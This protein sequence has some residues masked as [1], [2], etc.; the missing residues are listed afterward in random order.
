MAKQT[1]FGN[2][3]WLKMIAGI[4]KLNNAVKVTLGPRGRNVILQKKYGSHLITNDGVTIAKEI[5]LKDP[6]ED[7][8]AQMVKDVAIK[9]NDMAG[10]GTTTATILADAFIR[11]G[12]KLITAGADPMALKRGMDKA[13]Q[14]VVEALEEV[15]I[16]VGDSKEKVQQ[17]ATISA[18]DPKVGELI[19]EV[20]DMVGHDGVITVEESQTMGLEKEVVKGMQFDNGYISPYMVTDAQRME[21]IYE[22][23]YILI[24]DK[25]VSS[26][27]DL[28][29]LIEK[30]AAEGKKELVIIGED[31]EGEA[32]ATL[33]LNKIRGIFNVL[34]VK[35]PAY[36]DRRKEMLRDIAALTGGK[37]ISEELGLKLA[38]VEMSDLGRAKK[39]IADKDKTTIIEGKGA[40]EDVD[41]RISEIKVMMDKS[42]SDFDKEKL[43]ERLAKLAGGVGVIRVGA[44][45]EV[46]LKEKK[47]RIEDAVS[48]TKAAVAEGIVPGGGVALA[49]AAK[50]LMEMTEGD[51]DE[52]TGAHIVMMSLGI[53]LGQIAANAGEKT[54]VVLERVTS[55]EQGMG[56]DFSKPS[57]R[58]RMKKEDL[59]LINMVEAG[60][61][62]PKMVTR[63]ALQNA[64]SIAGIFLTTEGAVYEIPEEKSAQPAMS[65]DMGG[66]GG[67]GGMM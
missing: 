6:L 50:S 14:K 64:V 66:M 22:D 52:A 63:A 55:A 30:V 1:Q 7:M 26:L 34:A 19:A 36:G 9:T 42:T 53:P 20:M 38:N 40:R 13:A 28:V 24:T 4:E 60:I 5:E 46:E 51:D 10:D 21:A 45:T 49:Q 11:N 61:I 12:Y 3:V 29:P 35:A 23:A 8:G 2:D 57:K 47:L 56:F 27:Q 39:V 25:K 18:Q 16:P 58:G 44:A 54:D 65:A 43:V 48:A 15:A 59:Q 32:L 33:I 17:V 67:M 41:A 31:L 37:V 62:D